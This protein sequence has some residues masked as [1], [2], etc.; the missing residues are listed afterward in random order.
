MEGNGCCQSEGS[1]KGAYLKEL[2]KTVIIKEYTQ[3][4]GFTTRFSTCKMEVR[5]NTLQ[6]SVKKHYVVK[7]NMV[8]DDLA[9]LPRTTK[10]L[11][12]PS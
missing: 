9:L 10:I 7:P 12:F 6:Q 8:R 1:I 3:M 5:T 4:L 2:D 11:L